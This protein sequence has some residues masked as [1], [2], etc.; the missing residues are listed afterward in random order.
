MKS[1]KNHFSLI[2]ALFS[3]L[4]AI[5]IF[6]INNRALKAYEEKLSSN[7]SMI[8]VANTTINNDMFKQY[9]SNIDKVEQLSAD[10]LIEK[11]QQNISKKN[12]E[13]LKISMPKFYRIHLKTFPSPREIKGLTSQLLKNP[14][15]TK[16]EDFSNNHDTIY[17]LLLLFKEI[18]QLFALVIIVVTILL[19]AKEMRIW[20]FKHSERMNIMGLFGAPVWLRSAVLFRLAIVDAL[21]SSIFAIILFSIISKTAWAKQQL[22]IIGIDI[23][24]FKFM[25]DVVV[26]SIVSITIS[27]FLASMIVIGYKEEV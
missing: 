15:I 4:F 21:L 25:H 26:L 16:V 13:L 11:L 18:T 24:I 27:I 9:S 10:D 7:Y 20:Q 5:Q 22:N 1:L 12:I 19:I 2:L 23:D 8:V 6:T 3:I 17:K 14:S